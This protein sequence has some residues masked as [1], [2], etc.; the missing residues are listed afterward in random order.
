MEIYVEERLTG[1]ALRDRILA[2]YGS[3]EALEDAAGEEGNHMAWDDLLTVET[4][5]EEPRRLD[6]EMTVGTGTELTPAELDLLT[7]ARLHL[8]HVL[9]EADEPRNV[10]QL[11]DLVGRDKKNVS[12][13]LAIL[14]ELGL[15]ASERRGREK[16]CRPR[17]NDI[18]I[19]LGRG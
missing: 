12:E 6:A 9:A 4:L 5:E 11:A 3:R 16:L 13:D 19:V 17:G 1:R 2:R 7:P 15:V 14:E 18:H 10:T 8:L